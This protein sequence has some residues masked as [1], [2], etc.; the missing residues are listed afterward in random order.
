MNLVDRIVAV[1]SPMAGLQRASARAALAR[2]DGAKSDRLR[3]GGRSRESGDV[4]VNRDAATLRSIAR[5]LERNHDLVRGALG[6]FVRNVVGAKGITILPQPRDAE[7]YIDDMF[8]RQLLNL[9]RDWC[10]KPEVTHSMNWVQA[11]HLACRAWARDGELFSQHLQGPVAGLNHG[12]R[13]PY[14]IE[15]L[16][17]DMVP[18]DYTPTESVFGGI[19]FN[20]WNAPVAF[21]VHKRHPGGYRSTLSAD[22]KRVSA[23]RMMHVAVRD[24]FTAFRGVSILASVITRIEDLKDYEESE[25]VAARMAA[26]VCAQIKRDKEMQ[27]TPPA[28][29][30]PLAPRNLRMR[31]GMVV[32]QLLPGEEL[33]MVDPSRP[34][35]NLVGFRDGQLRA[36]AA[37]T[38]L[39]FSSVAR[40]Y[41]GTYSAQR[42]ELV[43]QDAAYKLMTEHFVARFVQPVWERFVETA[44]A[45]G[46]LRV[47]SNIRP[48]TVSQA[49]FRGP[50]MPW[51][52]PLKEANAL[53]Q[54]TRAGFKSSEQAIAER[55]GNLQD[56]YEQLAREREL[57][58]ELG[59]VLE[60]DAAT[61]T[62]PPAPEPAEPA[63]EPSRR[64]TARTNQRTRQRAPAHA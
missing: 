47:P 51:I 32:D 39:G 24:R 30:D 42:Q 29:F 15:L 34:N 43:E 20:D 50:P 9:F 1:F 12:T 40:N 23:D 64:T 52:D 4:V 21:Y 38:E 63:P 62:A 27:W 53:R 59:L 10:R 41:D 48:E 13:V 3:K 2:F 31:A 28:E 57:A 17:S 14:S 8:A 22:L 11:Q 7:D 26:A 45:S 58:A 36:F 37:G 16:E 55:G 35:P 61:D 49:E 33:A 19:E 6:V 60:A 18:L 5:D 44:I 54:L 56:V 25:R 46:L